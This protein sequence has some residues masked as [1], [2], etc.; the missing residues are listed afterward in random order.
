LQFSS[1]VYHDGDGKLSVTKQVFS[2][3][4]LQDAG[5]VCFWRLQNGFTSLLGKLLAR[6]S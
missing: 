6:N 4:S 1:K 5:E 2:K 3:L